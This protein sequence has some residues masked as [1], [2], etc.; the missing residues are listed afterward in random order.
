M[1]P[2]L[3]RLDGRMV[4]MFADIM[5]IDPKALTILAVIGLCFM[6]WLVVKLYKFLGE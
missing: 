3:R 2:A 4:P 1:T 6:P 5:H